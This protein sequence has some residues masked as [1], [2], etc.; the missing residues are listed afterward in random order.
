LG[1]YAFTLLKARLAKTR[2][3]TACGAKAHTFALENGSKTLRLL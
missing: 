1:T 3:E 2:K